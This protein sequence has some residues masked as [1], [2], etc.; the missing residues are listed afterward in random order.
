[1]RCPFS[2]F[3][4]PWQPNHPFSSAR[5]N[6]SKCLSNSEHSKHDFRVQMRGEC[7]KRLS[8]HLRHVHHQRLHVSL[9]TAQA[10]QKP[11]KGRLHLHALLL[12]M[13]DAEHSTVHNILIVIQQ[14]VGLRN[15]KAGEFNGNL[16]FY[17]TAGFN[18]RSSLYISVYL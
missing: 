7:A 15:I 3:I 4:C 10:A 1:M 11:A 12:D 18:I 2:L 17:G 13:L 9:F 16:R 5:R 8:G 14:G 6:C